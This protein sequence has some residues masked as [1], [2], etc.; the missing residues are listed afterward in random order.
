M[1]AAE[2]VPG[3]SGARD[4]DR[5]VNYGMALTVPQTVA[6]HLSAV[7]AVAD[8]EQAEPRDELE[9]ETV[10]RQAAEYAL[11]QRTAQWEAAEAEQAELRAELAALRGQVETLADRWESS[12]D[13]DGAPAMVD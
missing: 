1:T 5:R 4:D 12:V 9:E 6:G 7:M 10:A 8:A 11:H 13:W 2:N 3:V